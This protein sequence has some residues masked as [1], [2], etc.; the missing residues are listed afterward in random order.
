MLRTRGRGGGSHPVPPKQPHGVA[1]DRLSVRLRHPL[2][3]NVGNAQIG[4][5][6]ENAIVECENT[7]T[8]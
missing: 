5:E 1:S 2:P 7:E 4:N 3:E 8:K 6:H